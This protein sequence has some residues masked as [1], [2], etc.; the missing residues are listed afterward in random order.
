MPVSSRPS[1]CP[2]HPPPAPRWWCQDGAG[3]ASGG[4]GS[5]GDCGE[6]ISACGGC[7]HVGVCVGGGEG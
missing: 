4:G 2:P 5:C 7:I 3:P 6:I 1:D